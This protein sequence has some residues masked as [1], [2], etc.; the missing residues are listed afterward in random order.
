[1]GTNNGML[2]YIIAKRIRTCV[3][4]HCPQFISNFLR[5]SSINSR[6]RYEMLLFP[7]FQSALT[8]PGF[9]RNA[10]SVWPYGQ[11]HSVQVQDFKQFQAGLDLLPIVIICICTG[12][13]PALFILKNQLL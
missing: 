6:V 4:N 12:E 7:P 3:C 13:T 8:L 10:I 1:M 11:E 5:L 9:C 2:M